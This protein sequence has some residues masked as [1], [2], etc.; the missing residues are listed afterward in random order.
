MFGLATAMVCCAGMAWG[1]D[2]ADV[3]GE[4]LLPPETRFL[5]S[6]PN[7]PDLVERGAESSLGKMLSDPAF[8]PFLDQ[9]RG[10]LDEVSSK[11]QEK[12]GLSLKDLGSLPQGEFTIALVERPARKL[13]A[14]LLLDYGDNEATVDKLLEQLQ[15]GLKS[16][17]AEH[18]T[19]SVGEVEIQVFEFPKTN[20]NPYNQLAYFTADG[21]LVM[22]SDVAPLKAVLERWEGES[23][24]TLAED[25]V[26]KYIF[27]KCA[28]DDEEPSIKW[29]L[30]VVGLVKSGVA[31]VQGQNPQAGLVLGVLPILGLDRLKGMGGGM[32]IAVGDF[33]SVSKTFIYAEQPPS[34]VLGLFQ[35]PAVAQTPPKWV[36]ADSTMYVGVNWNVAE[37]YNAVE[38]VLDSFQGPGATANLLDSVALQDGGPQIHPKKDFL[39]HLTGQVVAVTV[40]G[41]ASEDDDEDAPVVPE[42][43]ITLGLKDAN[44]MRATLEKAAKSPTFP[45]RI[46][47]IDSHTVYEI[48]TDGD[49]NM[50]ISVVGSELVIA[51]SQESLQAVIKG[52]TDSPLADDEDFA[53]MLK[54]IPAQVSMLSYSQQDSQL[55]SAY[56][57]LRQQAGDEFQGLDLSTLP[58]FDELQKY[59]RPNAGYAVPDKRGALFVGFT[60]AD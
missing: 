54:H 37:A 31:M 1:Q 27:E 53:A 57:M 11:L 3:Y 32:D 43:T 6:I 20:D 8:Q 30:D 55:K 4:Q 18:K 29:Y 28:T 52:E 33:E 49:Q 48:P 14:I 26:F 46:Q 34:G 16:L 15:G 51:L 50:F 25:S 38:T 56:D 24:E 45:G 12:I 22:S 44:K 36:S 39:D 13:N 58:D 17:D 40:G 2:D 23:D 41:E 35:F 7:V 42:L 21:Y 9:V 60:L 10:K 19:E 47:E 5:F 59:A